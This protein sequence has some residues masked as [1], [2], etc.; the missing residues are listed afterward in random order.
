AFLADQPERLLHA[1]DAA[2]GGRAAN[3]A[4]GVGPEAAED[5]AAADGRAGTG[6]GAAGEARQVPRVLRDAETGVRV[7]PADRVLVQAE[8]P[9]DDRAGRAQLLDH[10]RVVA[11]AP[12][13]I[14]HPAVGRRRGVPRGDDVL[15]AE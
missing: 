12:A 9:E 7:G 14:E 15:D 2:E 4:A 1:A 13:P 10:G 5:H 3:R 11:L 8:L 6:A